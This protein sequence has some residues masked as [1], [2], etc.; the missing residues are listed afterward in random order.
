MPNRD[1]YLT[2]VHHIRL[3]SMRLHVRHVDLY[4][5][6][7]EPVRWEGTML[8]PIFQKYRPGTFPSKKLKPPPRISLEQMVA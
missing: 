8:S 6:T 1:A 5:E 2:T 3:H 7:V 4:R